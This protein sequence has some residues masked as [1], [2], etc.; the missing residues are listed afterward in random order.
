MILG[1]V[2]IKAEANVTGP[3]KIKHV[4]TNHTYTL[5]NLVWYAHQIWCASTVQTGTPYR[6]CCAHHFWCAQHT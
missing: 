3:P 1:Q 4:N 6:V 2:Y 5:K